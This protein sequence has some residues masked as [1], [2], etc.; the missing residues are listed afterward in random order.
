MST[1]IAANSHI[2]IQLSGQDNAEAPLLF[3][4]FLRQ[5]DAVRHALRETERVI[6]KRKEQTIDFRVIRLSRSSPTCIELE[7]VPRNNEAIDAI[8]LV[9]NTFIESIQAIQYRSEI[10]LEFDGS[11]LRAFA[12]MGSLLGKNISS[13]ELE[14]DGNSVVVSQTMVRNAEI[15]LDNKEYTFGSLSGRLEKINLHNNQ[16]VFS[17]YP[18]IGPSR[19]V[20][21]KFNKALKEKAAKALTHFVD[22]HGRLVYNTIDNYPEEIQVQEIEIREEP[23]ESP[24]LC[25]LQGIAADATGNPSEEFIGELRDEWG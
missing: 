24:K 12:N 4:D 1:D 8:P 16:N 19:G 6:T 14:A 25:D 20:K 13:M 2:K 23:K 3:E 7:A 11:A 9:N 22:V 18:I 5:L 15:I 17:I 10:P 21:C